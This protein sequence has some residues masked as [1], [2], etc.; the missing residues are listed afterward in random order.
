MAPVTSCASI[1]PLRLNDL[2]DEA[3]DWRM[4]PDGA[5]GPA[6][7]LWYPVESRTYYVTLLMDF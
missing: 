3:D 6:R 2:L 1:A 5:S 4:R 7:M